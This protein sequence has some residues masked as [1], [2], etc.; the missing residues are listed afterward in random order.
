[1]KSHGAITESHSAAASLAKTHWS[2]SPPT[3]WVWQPRTCVHRQAPSPNLAHLAEEAEEAEGPQDAELL[4]PR[5]AAV[6]GARVLRS[7][8]IRV[9][10]KGGQVVGYV[11]YAS[12]QVFVELLRVAPGSC[13]YGSGVKVGK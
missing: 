5:V 2:A 9:R 7:G 6:R 11:E 10:G 13:R 4:D 12:M 1:M 8:R 3:T